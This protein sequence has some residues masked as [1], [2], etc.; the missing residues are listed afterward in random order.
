MFLVLSTEVE[1]VTL[2]SYNAP[3]GDFVKAAHG[4]CC[5]TTPWFP[6]NKAKF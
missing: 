2:N 4:R 5:I 3:A 6:L 1:M